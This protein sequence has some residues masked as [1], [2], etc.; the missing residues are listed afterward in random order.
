LRHLPLHIFSL[1]FNSHVTVT[2]TKQNQSN[3]LG[4][5]ILIAV[6]VMFIFWDITLH[7]PVQ[8]N[9]VLEEYATPIFRVCLLIVSPRFVFG[10]PF[11]L[12][13]GDA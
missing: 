13:D 7:S 12:E 2:G 3:F 4:L 6:P 8:V 5:D 9:G 1:F 11:D 10:L